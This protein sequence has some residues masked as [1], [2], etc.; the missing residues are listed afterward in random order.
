MVLNHWKNEL[1]RI[2]QKNS[3]FTNSKNCRSYERI[4][5]FNKKMN[6]YISQEFV[7]RLHLT[8]LVCD[9]I[10]EAC[11]WNVRCP[12]CGESKLLY[13]HG[14]LPLLDNSIS[15]PIQ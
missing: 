12:S 11:Q 15:C 8:A 10:Y 13:G 7:R 1:F 3:I 5:S 4:K 14:R 2:F 9:I 6:S